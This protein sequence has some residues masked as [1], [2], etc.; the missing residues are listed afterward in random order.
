MR[1]PCT[2]KDAPAEQRGIWRTYFQVQEFGQKLRSF[3]LLK[4]GKTKN[5]SGASTH[6]FKETRGA[7]IRS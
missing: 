6:H 5:E 3:L 7:R 2:K 4:A 1:R